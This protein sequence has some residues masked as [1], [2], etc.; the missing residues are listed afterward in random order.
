MFGS[1]DA[2][3]NLN[4]PT[5]AMRSSTAA[6]LIASLPAPPV[7]PDTTKV[8]N[9]KIRL[10]GTMKA[11]PTTQRSCRGVLMKLWSLMMDISGRRKRAATAAKGRGRL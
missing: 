1:A 11:R 8:T 6:S 2:A 9:R 4:A 5:G 7:L 3:A 10:M